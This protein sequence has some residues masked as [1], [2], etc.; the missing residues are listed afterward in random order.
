MDEAI[1]TCLNCGKQLKPKHKFCP[2]CGQSTKVSRLQ[3]GDI[4]KNLQ[5]R[6]LHA[7]SG[8]LRLTIDLALRPG[9]LALDYVRGKRKKHYNPLKYLMLSAGISVFIN[10]YFHLLDNMHQV[11]NTGTEIANRY[12]NLIILFSVPISAFFS[13]LLFKRKGFNYAENLVLQAYLGGFRTVFFIFIF[14]P[15][16]VWKGDYYYQSLAGYLG[17]WLVYMAWA[18]NQFFG[19]PRWLTTLKAVLVLLLN[20][21]VISLC[22]TLAVYLKHNL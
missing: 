1:P 5:K 17:L 19:G 2:K 6:V 8:I 20:Q 13:W 11:R 10:E 12:Y 15:L 22:I 7:E 9:K 21:I 4:R 3:I 18:K 16:I 14:T